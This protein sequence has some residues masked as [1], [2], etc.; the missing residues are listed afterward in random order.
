MAKLNLD[1]YIELL[2]E[3]VLDEK[4]SIL[5][6]GKPEK[7][8]EVLKEFYNIISKRKE[9]LCSY[10]DASEIQNPL[11]FF[12]PILK[13]KY[14]DDYE[15]EIKPH[16][17]GL[18][19]DKN[20]RGILDLAEICGQ[21]LGSKILNER[22]FPIILI[23]GIEELLFKLDFSHLKKSDYLKIP[24]AGSVISQEFGDSLR[25]SIFGTK[26]GVFCGSVKDCE[27]MEYRDTLGNYNYLFYSE[28]FGTLQI[29]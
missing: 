23:N 6:Y 18:S 5:L 25:K 2:C 22:K 17:E 3:S 21:N 24:I 15:T 20:K 12:V 10:Y 19:Q 4:N 1:R 11:D 7:T 9:F 29:E 28:N 26:K 8:L 16:I 27:S 13:L 14:G